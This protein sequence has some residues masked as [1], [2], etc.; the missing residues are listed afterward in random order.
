MHRRIAAGREHVR[1]CRVD[2]TEHGLEHEGRPRDARALP[3]REALLVG[4]DGAAFLAAGAA[5]ALLGDSALA[6]RWDV[7]AALT[8]AFA[9]TVR[10]RFDNG[11]GYALPTQ[12]VFVPALLVSP[13]HL[14]PLVA[15]AGWLLGRLPDVLS[16]A[17]HASRLLVVPGNCWFAIGPAV[18]LTAAGGQGPAWEDWWLYLLALAA[19]FAGDVV[20]NALRDRLVFG[21]P[22]MLELRILAYAWAIDLALSPIGLLAAFASTQGRFAFLAVLPLAGLLGAFS[23]ERTR[24]FEAER[25]AT[26]SREALIAGTSHELQTPL[27]VLSGVIDT[28][29]G[30]PALTPERRA[31]A[32][33]TMQ[34]QAAHLRYLVGQF[35]DYARLKAGQSLLI[36]TR[37]TDVA[38]MVA[39]VAELWAGSGVHTEVEALPVRAQVDPARLRTVLMALVANAVRHGPAEGPVLLACGRAGNRAVVEVADEGPGIAEQRLETVFSEFDPEATAGEGTGIGLFLARTALRAQGGDIQVENRSGGGLLARVYLPL[40]P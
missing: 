40:T 5:L 13:P 30:S 26:R 25:T 29:A 17:T 6:W 9:L 2:G 12:L 8:L 32:Y 38:G 24:R 14:A 1:L 20:A 36:S 4:L 16:G 11:T 3:R 34:R 10:A 22:P 21:V 33:A 39:E 18:V 28:L 37:P 7:G 19:Q 27:A 35:V 23:V 15:V 31:T